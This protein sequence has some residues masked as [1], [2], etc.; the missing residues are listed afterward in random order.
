MSERKR[1]RV[2]KRLKQRIFFVSE[3]D[4]KREIS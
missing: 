4:R 1:E 2:S 3:R